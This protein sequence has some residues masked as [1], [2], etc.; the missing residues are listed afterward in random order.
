MLTVRTPA[1]CIWVGEQFVR[2]TGAVVS[3]VDL[4]VT[5]EATL[6]L[7]LA[8]VQLEADA[9]GHR[10]FAAVARELQHRPLSYRVHLVNAIP[11]RV[12][13][14]TSSALIVTCVALLRALQGEPCG[15]RAIFDAALRIERAF[16][17][18]AVSGVDTCACVY[19]GTHFYAS[20]DV[21]PV[22]LY[23]QYPSHVCLIPSGLPHEASCAEA[24]TGEGVA[25]MTALVARFRALRRPD[26]DLG[27]MLGEAHALLRAEGLSAPAVDALVYQRFG[28]HAKVTGRGRGGCVLALA[29]GEDAT[30]LHRIVD[31]GVR[32]KGNASLHVP[33]ALQPLGVAMKLNQCLAAGAAADGVACSNIALVKYWGK[34]GTAQV[35]ANASVSLALPYCTTRTRVTVLPKTQT[36]HG[37]DARVQ[38][39]VDAVVRV[40]DDCHVSIETHNSFPTACGV[41][42][43]ASGFAA[44]VR[45]LSNLVGTSSW[46]PAARAHWEQ[47]WARLGSG[48][49]IRS[50]CADEGLVAWRG[51]SAQTHPVHPSLQ[52]LEHALVLFDPLPKHVSSSEGHARAGTSPFYGA[53]VATADALVEDVVHA[54]AQGDLATVRRVSEGEAQSMHMVMATS[55]PPLRYLS[56]E[57]LAFVARFVRFRADYG[58]GDDAFY[59]IDAGSNIHLLFQPH[60]KEAVLGFVRACKC[61]GTLHRGVL[62]HR[63]RV[64]ALSGKRYAG[65]TTLA[66]AL[67]AHATHPLQVVHL[68][69]AIKK[70]YFHEQHTGFVLERARKE[71][72]RARMIAYAERARADDSHYWCRRAWEALA[73]APAT[74]LVTD[75]RRA[76]D[77]EFWRAHASAV[78]VVRVECGDAER[79]RRG[80]TS[81]PGVDDVPSETGLD[82]ATFDLTL[83]QEYDATAVVRRLGL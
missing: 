25:H 70:D 69:T 26:D 42:S 46:T 75:V 14:G 15:R 43:S 4:Y 39:F 7:G 13:L 73:A 51:T 34:V 30:H 6:D 36:R 12:G 18:D 24:L 64:V 66:N 72:H 59:T 57:A 68:S 56:D 76:S 78:T 47:Q 8:D 37:V 54:F 22:P 31:A 58:V 79:T 53:R 28:G 48:S 17:G 2:H 82:D 23:R 62:D 40:P 45:A 55:T 83:D 74:V 60:V 20:A 21:P 44:L 11:T 77:L 67:V 41:A 1:K 27:A 52:D 38:R 33:G 10:V 3:A 29:E 71:E 19:G 50:V 63:Y 35:G 16:L 49:A 80:W 5:A 9:D 32:V 61:V 81:V 65:K